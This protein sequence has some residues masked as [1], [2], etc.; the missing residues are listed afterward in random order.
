MSDG[1]SVQARGGEALTRIQPPFS[2]VWR[3][4][5]VEM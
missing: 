4:S 1:M 2:L 5:G 3:L